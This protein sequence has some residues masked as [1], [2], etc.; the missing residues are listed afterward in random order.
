MINFL[1]TLVAIAALAA[2]AQLSITL[3]EAISVAPITAQSLVLFLIARLL[4]WKYSVLSVLLYLLLGIIGL[5]VFSGFSSGWE[6]VVGKSTGYFVGFIFAAFVIGLMAEKSSA[7][8]K[9]YLLEFLIGSVLIL[10]FGAI[11]LLRFI[12]L[13]EALSKGV[14]PFIPGAFIKLLLAAVI[15]AVYGKVKQFL[16]TIPQHD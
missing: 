2:A 1:K 14:K 12:P 13:E 16:T 10:F 15:L 8:F 5:P 3:S 11:F 9:N 7:Q 6:V 4:P